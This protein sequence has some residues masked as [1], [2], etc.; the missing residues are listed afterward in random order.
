M[1]INHNISAMNSYRNLKNKNDRIGK[2]LERLSSGL[3]I[4]KAGDD[5]AGLAISEKMRAQV[6]GLAMAARNAQDGISLIQTAEGALNETHAILQRMRELAVQSAND[7]NTTAD[8]AQLQKEMNQLRQEVDRIADTTEFNT[9]VLMTGTFSGN[10]IRFHIG[11]NSGQFISLQ[12]GNMK[13]SALGISGAQASLSLSITSNTTAD[14]SI[15]T[16]NDAI[17]AVSTQRARFGAIQNRIEHTIKNLRNVHENLQASESRIRDAD[18][19]DE[20]TVFSK[21]RILAQSGTS[22]LAQANAS[23]QGVLQLLQV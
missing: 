16:I 23:P 15:T 1:I 10:G 13:A 19:A 6:N 7:T 21:D 8:R 3:R 9:R 11:A 12:I 5:A 2:S 14:S 22:M 20:M 4:N 18:M 17:E